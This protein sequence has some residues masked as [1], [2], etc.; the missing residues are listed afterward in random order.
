MAT[1]KALDG[2]PYAGN[3]HVAPS[4]CYGGTS[5]FDEGGSRTGGNAEA[6]VSTLH[7]TAKCRLLSEVEVY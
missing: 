2:K 3:P 4:Q 5:R 6:W 1:G 7:K